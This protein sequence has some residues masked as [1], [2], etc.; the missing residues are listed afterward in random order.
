MITKYA[1]LAE[2]FQKQGGYAMEANIRSVLHGMGFG[3]TDPSTTVSSLS[4]GQKTR[5]ALARL[6][7]IKPD[8]LLLDEP[9][10]HLD[11]ATL[12]WLEA[13]LRNYPGA[14]LVVSHDRYFLDALVDTIYE[15]ERTSTRKYTGNYTRFIEL[16]AAEHERNLRV[17][18][19]QQDEIARMEDF[20]QRNIARA[21]TTKR[22]QSR[23]AMLDRIVPVDRPRGDLRKATFRFEVERASGKDVLDVQQLAMSYSAEQAPLFQNVSFTAHRGD[24]I[25]LI[26]P[27]GI[28]KTTLLK[29]LVGTMEPT[30]G[31]IVWGTNV[32]IGYYD[33]EQTGL[34]K[35]NT[36]LEELWNTFPHLEEVRIRT[37]LGNFLFLGEDVLKKISALSGGEK[38][39]VA[40]AKLMLL[41]ANVLIMDEPTNHLD[42]VSKEVLESALL[43]YEG[44]I[45]FISHD[46]YFLNRIAEFVLELS[47]D[48]V[49]HFLG[50]YDDYIAKKEEI[51]E[52][53][54]MNNNLRPSVPSMPVASTYEAVKQSK[55]EDRA[56]QRRIEQLEQ[57]IATTEQRISDFELKLAD[58]DIFKDYN[59]VEKLQNQIDEDR[60]LL[61]TTYKEW[62]NLIE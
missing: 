53:A 32:T 52:L 30:H 57:I 6:L 10:N 7:L 20:I 35:N 2:I 47:S 49:Q 38:A 19:R 14:V 46:R 62:E 9:T 59:A 23:R 34:N 21:S 17:Y 39:R 22:A 5:L 12:R 11:I 58:P 1:A 13:W 16:K 60:M 56:R 26:G 3:D 28:G 37:V 51:A 31:R 54:S 36:V 27:N 43:D 40:L 44:T 15:I 41:N 48:G 42:L 25:A 29:A 8:L 55:R 4:G 45:L 50:N 18:E 24:A 33:Q 61:T